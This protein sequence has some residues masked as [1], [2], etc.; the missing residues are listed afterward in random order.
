MNNWIWLIALP[1]ASSPLVYIFGRLFQ[2]SG[3]DHK[4]SSPAKWASLVILL[5]D[6][7]FLFTSPTGIYANSGG[8]ALIYQLGMVSLRLDGLSLLLAFSVLFLG[9]LVTLYSGQYLANDENQEKYYALLNAMIGAMIGL[10][11][12]ND[13]FNLWIWFEMMAI[14]SYMLVAFYR[15]QSASLEAGVKYLVQSAA[16][17]VL[18]LL[19]IA[20]VF[21]QTG[22][23]DLD[24]IR[25]ALQTASI[26]PAI[27]IQL[28]PL[29]LIAAGALFRHR[30]RRQNSSGPPAH[31]A[32]RCAFSGAQRDQ[33]HAFWRGHRNRPGS[34][35]QN[36]GSSLLRHLALGDAHPGFWRFEHAGRQ[37]IGAAP[38]AS[39]KVAGILQPKP[40]RIYAGWDRCRHILRSAR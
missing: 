37:L 16:G 1:L 28:S 7:G 15:Q 21:S 19:G 20:L 27:E 26:L 14:A 10:G 34:P 22:T 35:A 3:R 8:Q 6:L 24:K 18:V 17:S 33:R 38:D 39:Q 30:L 23:L 12:A 11:C 32:S 25:T 29:P 4:F 31:L 36:S 9:T 40:R 13:L 2:S 5:C